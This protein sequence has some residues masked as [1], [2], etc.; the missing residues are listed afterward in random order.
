MVYRRIYS[1]FVRHFQTLMNIVHH[2][3]DINDGNTSQ[4]LQ[5]VNKPLRNPFA[6][7]KPCGYSLYYIYIYMYILC[8]YIYICTFCV[9]IY[10]YTCIDIYIYIYIHY[11]YIYTLYIYTLYIYIHFIYIYIHYLYI[12]IYIIYIYIYMIGFLRSDAKQSACFEMETR[13]EQFVG[14]KR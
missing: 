10:I 3:G 4:D 7:G 5:A 14:F 12:Y 2:S 6:I 1:Y 11:I 9:S 8:I 13:D